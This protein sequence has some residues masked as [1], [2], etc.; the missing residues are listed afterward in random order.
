MFAAM[1]MEDYLHVL[2]LI[3]TAQAMPVYAQMDSEVQD[4]QQML[5]AVSHKLEKIGFGFY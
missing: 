2:R 1:Q 4:L 5:I 3:C